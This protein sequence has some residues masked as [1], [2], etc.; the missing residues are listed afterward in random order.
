MQC[1]AYF[2][3]LI[4]IH[5]S[6]QIYSACCDIFI[7]MYLRFVNHSLT[8]KIIIFEIFLLEI[9]SERLFTDQNEARH[10][11]GPDLDPNSLLRLSADGKS[12]NWQAKSCFLI[13]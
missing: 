13:S 10:T 7:Y 12:R 3:R 9:L 6:Q 5:Y 11:V 4:L 1:F 2:T 8:F